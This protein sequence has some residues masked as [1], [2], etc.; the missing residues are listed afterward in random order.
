MLLSDK[1]EDFLT[2]VAYP[3]ITTF[4]G[5]ADNK[6]NAQGGKVRANL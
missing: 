6:G 4:E 2:L 5:G 1:L 3:H